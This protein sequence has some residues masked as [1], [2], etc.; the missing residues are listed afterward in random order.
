MTEIT[1]RT[2]AW[3]LDEE[4]PFTFP[5]GWRVN[6]YPPRDAPEMDDDAIRRAFEE[7]IGTERLSRIARG[8]TSATIIVDDLSRPTPAARIAPYVLAELREGGVPEDGIRFVV[9]GG[10]HRPLTEAE[11]ALK[12][13]PEVAERYPVLN[14]NAYSGQLVGL[15][16]LEDGTPV[17]VNPAVAE[18]EVVIAL[19]GIV[20]HPSAGL[21]GGG[22][23]ILPGV[24]GIATIAYNHGLYPPRRRGAPE[25]Q[26]EREDMRDN[27]EKVARYVG[28]DAIVNCVVNSQRA[29]AGLFV[30]DVV[31]AHRAGCRF[32]ERVYGTPLPQAVVD[33]AD[34]VVFNAYPLDYDPVQI[35][36]S[37]WPI[38]LFANARKV[39]IDPAT[40]GILYHGLTNQMD[41]ARFV[42]LQRAGAGLDAIPAP[43]PRSIDGTIMVSAGFP[44]ADFGHRF[45]DGTLYTTWES[46]V[47]D[48]ERAC[49]AGEVAVLPCAAIQIPKVV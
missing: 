47:A 10:A 23:L 22:K 41:Y 5:D 48:L 4:R 31:A 16:N 1:L 46:A 32:A 9:G 29:V 24:V 33:G 38:G 49:P 28:L 30:G 11:I 19:A 6:V 20:P 3:K 37:A 2:Q 43:A 12:V 8:K 40:D 34:I 35:V 25:R 7:P 36:K 45:T 21:G 39:M 13:G 15:G 14:H 27:L 44:V 26:G 42:A 18:A 17:Y